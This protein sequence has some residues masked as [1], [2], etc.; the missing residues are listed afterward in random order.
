MSGRSVIAL[1]RHDLPTPE[2]P[3]TNTSIGGKRLYGLIATL[4]YGFEK[5]IDEKKFSI[6]NAMNSAFYSII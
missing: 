3:K 6:L 2:R 5:K 4:L 1:N